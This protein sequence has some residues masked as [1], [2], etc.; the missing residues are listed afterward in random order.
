MCDLLLKIL[1][2]K[3]EFMKSICFFFI[4]LICFF[5]GFGD[6]DFHRSALCELLVIFTFVWIQYQINTAL[7]A[8]DRYVVSRYHL[9]FTNFKIKGQNFVC[10]IQQAPWHFKPV[11]MWISRSYRSDTA[12]REVEKN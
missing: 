4:L 7:D 12:C 2:V 6:L 10:W 8:A 5:P 1:H 11:S 9:T 3:Y